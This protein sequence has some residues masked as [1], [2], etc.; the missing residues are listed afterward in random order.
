MR[1]ATVIA[2]AA[3]VGLASASP[4]FAHHLDRRPECPSMPPS[5]DTSRSSEGGLSLQ[6]G[7]FGLSGNASRARSESDIMMRHGRGFEDWSAAVL[8]AHVCQQNRRLYRDDPRRQRD[9]LVALRDRLLAERGGHAGSES[10]AFPQDDNT[11]WERDFMRMWHPLAISGF[12]P[13]AATYAGLRE[14]IVH[15]DCRL[16]RQLGVDDCRIASETPRGYGFGT[17][18]HNWLRSLRMR[19]EYRYSNWNAR[20][21]RF[22]VRLATDS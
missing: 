10:Q 12:M 2:V 21:V 4:A 17:A 8:M 1:N 16:S 11:S 15:V 20:R 3:L 14:G 18:A 9:E 5:A 13:R 6:I 19:D 22:G 7:G